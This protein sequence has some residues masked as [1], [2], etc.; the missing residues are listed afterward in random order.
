MA[1]VD[2][3][4]CRGYLRQWVGMV[5]GNN[6]HIH[7]IL[8]THCRLW[9]LGSVVVGQAGVLATRC[10][11]VPILLVVIGWGGGLG[12][13]AQSHQGHYGGSVPLL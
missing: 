9:S 1:F 2:W 6:R 13:G 8:D 10:V 11:L 3:K 5:W 12:S 4:R 7:A